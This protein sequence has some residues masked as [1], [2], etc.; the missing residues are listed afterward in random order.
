VDLFIYG[1][2]ITFQLV[3]LADTIRIYKKY[4][5]ETARVC[6]TTIFTL[7]LASVI[8]MLGHFF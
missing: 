4:G 2:I 6:A 1:I 3:F 7:L 8:L 5:D